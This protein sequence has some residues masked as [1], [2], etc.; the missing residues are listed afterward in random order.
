M[1]EKKDAKDEKKKDEAASAPEVVNVPAS[2]V[3]HIA[4]RRG[5]P[6]G[7]GALP[8]RVEA[9]TM[10]RRAL[11]RGPRPGLVTGTANPP[12]VTGRETVLDRLRAQVAAK[13]L[14]LASEKASTSKAKAAA[15]AFGMN[16]FLQLA[17]EVLSDPAVCH[18]LLE[19]IKEA[20]AGT[21]DAS[22]FIEQMA[23]ALVVL[24][25]V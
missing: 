7:A 18:Q 20:K 8:G 14:E 21:T 17:A 4:A 19:W 22:G 5:S 6:D 9:G 16:V 12:V 3:R 23:K 11:E 1:S 2:S 15:P 25:T 10:G 24:A 13:A